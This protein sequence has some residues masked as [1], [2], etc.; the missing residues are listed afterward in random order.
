MVTRKGST[1]VP[2]PGLELRVAPRFRGP[3]GAA[4][5]GFA[6]GSLAALLGGAAEVTLRRP[7]PLGRPL[8]VRRDGA[9]SLVV[10]DDGVLLAEASQAVAGVEL[11]V[12]AAVTPQEADAAAGRSRYYDAPAF[13]GCF[14]CGPARAPG[15][16]LRVLP[17]P[18]AGGTLL[19]APWTPDPS[20]AG[21]DGRVRAEV[22][23][24]A[25]DC[26]SGLA[27]TDAAALPAD[28]AAVLGRM[29]ASLAALPRPGDRCRVVAWPLGR[30]GR[31]LAAGS[32]LLGPGGAVLAA[33]RTV[34][35][36]VPRSF[37]GAGG[38]H[39]GA[40]AAPGTATLTAGGG[41]DRR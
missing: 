7:L 23:W 31:K 6:S 32:A 1:D 16:G 37:A 22:V 35:V 36:T 8:R 39:R 38:P 15:D 21:A 26:P 4:N 12:P 27:A 3:P 13:P 29:A 25:L 30:D 14:V 41:E 17:G 28:T 5:G 9:R 18:V 34:W 20:V 11:A 10:E 24:A 40:E 19:A 2:A 33:A